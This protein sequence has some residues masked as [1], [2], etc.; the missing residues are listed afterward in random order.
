MN[1]VTDIFVSSPDGRPI[2]AVEVKNPQN[3]S[4][5]VASEVRRNLLAHGLISQVPYFLLL[6]QDSGFL[7]ERA[8]HNGLN[9]PPTYEFSMSKIVSRYWPGTNLK[10]R[11]SGSQL[12]LI[13]LQWLLSLTSLPQEAYAEPEKSLARSGFLESMRG[14]TVLAEARS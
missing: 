7:W 3:L 9:A 6:S 1:A 11:L 5:D 10:E 2:A 4:R 8:E 13:V 12:E 14:A